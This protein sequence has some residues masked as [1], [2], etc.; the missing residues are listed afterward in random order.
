MSNTR[1]W[2]NNNED[3]YNILINKVE[4]LVYM[5]ITQERAIHEI[6]AELPDQTPDGKQW[7]V[8]DIFDLV[9]EEYNEQ[10]QYS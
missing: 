7:D 6:L 2:I 10:L 4:L 3:F 8:D 5:C 1:L 9:E